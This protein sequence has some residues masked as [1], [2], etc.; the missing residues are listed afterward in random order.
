MKTLAEWQRTL[1]VA[2]NNK[3]PNNTLGTFNRVSSLQEQLDDIKVAID[4]ENGELESGDHAHQDANHRIGALIAEA[5]ILAEERGADIESEL[6]KVL[7]W[8]NK[9]TES[10]E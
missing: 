1:K 8:F 5:L 7:K 4:V 9:T 10:S 2:A 3:F 6:K